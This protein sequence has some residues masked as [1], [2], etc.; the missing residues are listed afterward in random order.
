MQTYVWILLAVYD[1]TASKSKN[2][3]YFYLC[4]K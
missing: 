4:R 2:K 3:N 1:V